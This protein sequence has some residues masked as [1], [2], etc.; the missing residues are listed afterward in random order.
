MTRRIPIKVDVANALRWLGT[1]YRNPADAI[2]EHISN[3]IDEHLKAKKM[4]RAHASCDVVFTLEKRNVTID[5][6]YGMDRKEFEN[7]LQRVADSA[8]KAID[9]NQI[10]RLGIG[11]FSFQQIGKKC[12]FF[13]KKVEDGECIRVTLREGM[14]EAEFDTALKRDTLDKPGIRILISELKFDPTKPRGPLSPEKLSKAFAEKF[15]GYLKQG[16]LHV[17]LNTGGKIYPV[18]PL[19]IDLQ[20]IAKD[21][22]A[23]H[24]AGEP[25]KKVILD[26]YFDPS[27]KGKVGIRH[28]GVVVVEDI[29]QL[30]AY[31]LED[32]VYAEGFVKGFIDADFLEPLP[33]RTGFE[34]N[35]EWISF[36]EL[37]DKQLPQIGAE[38]EQLKQRE[39]E[40]ALSEIQKRA[41]ELAR[42]ILDLDEFKDLELPGGLRKIRPPTERQSIER[43]P[44]V[45][46][47]PE[48]HPPKEPGERKEPG[49]LRINYVEIPFETGPSRHSQF[50]GGVIQANELN[51]DFKQ[52]KI[53]PDESKVAY[54]TL[55]IGKET[56]AYNDKTGASDD[57]LEKLLGFYFKLKSKI[58][59]TVSVPGKR[60]PG[61]AKNP[62]SS[63]T[64][65]K[66][67]DS[68]ASSKSQ[69]A[70]ARRL[71]GRKGFEQLK[72][73]L[74]PV[75]RL[76]KSGV[77][78]TDAFHRIAKD[79]DV[80]YQTANAQCTVRLGNIS[81]EKFVELI[82]SNKIKSFLK[83]RF[84]DK[85]SLIERDLTF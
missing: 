17:D 78:H 51:P 76:I 15:N 50:L 32:S 14:D 41:I 36:L 18:E 2:K 80:T 28:T 54:A 21:L 38:V 53:G 37:L 11:I 6:P 24:L 34:E 55:I 39:K 30:S 65:P 59:P 49:G 22:P 71:L 5:Y 33:A 58:A 3:A 66:Q 10:G 56:I 27:G 75:I 29:R 12:T 62:F 69:P 72:D 52:E 70:G 67:D 46:A 83:E 79:L 40:K 45:A 44:R 85:A 48:I 82:K 26:I 74:I 68:N 23:L 1:L 31:G 57:Y 73:Y 43:E 7:A 42:E 64:Q 13:S 77:K 8:K 61:R 20:R 47:E 60:G 25:S 35:G 4:G 9:I 19:K 63:L 84:P 81:T 16:W